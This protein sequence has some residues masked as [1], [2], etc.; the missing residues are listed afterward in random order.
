[1][2]SDKLQVGIIGVGIAAMTWHVP[3]LLNTGRA[4]IAAICRRSPERLA[5]AREH[6]GVDRAY[7]DWREL[8][9]Q[10][11]LDAVYVG[12]P[13]DL[14]AEP[15]IAALQRGLHVLVDKP[16]ALIAADAW[17]MVAAARAA[18]RV[19]TVTY[20]QRLR[21]LWQ[22]AKQ[23]LTA[24]RIGTV[25]QVSL[26]FVADRS[27]YWEDKTFPEHV[28]N[29]YRNQSGMPEAFFDW[30][31]AGNWRVDPGRRG[32]GMFADPGT[33]F[34][35]RALWLAG[36]PATQVAALS[37]PGDGPVERVMAVQARLA[38]GVLLSLVSADVAPGGGGGKSVLIAIGE[39]GILT[40]DWDGSLWIERDGSRE[41]VDTD[42]P[43]IPLYAAFV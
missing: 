26:T 12:T 9:E 18:D 6:I 24:G 27:F 4:E 14:H 31:L 25:R 23:A 5:L 2:D 20:G 35:D 1:M 41:R 39:E 15:T 37:E 10:G 11:D 7:T 38:N 33:H 8:L 3:E 17:A 32:G 40:V 36:A 43:N 16:M 30:D 34:V 13:H 42:I 28:R 21:G 29:Y 22:A 19:L